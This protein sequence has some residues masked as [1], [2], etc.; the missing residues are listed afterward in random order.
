[1]SPHGVHLEVQPG[2]RRPHAEQPALLLA[3]MQQVAFAE[4][5]SWKCVRQ[6]TS[7]SRARFNLGN[8]WVEAAGPGR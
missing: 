5:P 7:L 8:L 3:G 6:D 2:P 4:F 1:V